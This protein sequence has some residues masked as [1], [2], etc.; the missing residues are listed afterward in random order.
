MNLVTLSGVVA[1]WTT[2]ASPLY[3]VL[4]S[5]LCMVRKGVV[6]EVIPLFQQSATPIRWTTG[7][8]PHY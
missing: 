4:I 3:F 6:V 8:S 2:F 5:C 7:T 1:D